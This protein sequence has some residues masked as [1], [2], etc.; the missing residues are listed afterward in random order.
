VP[1]DHAGACSCTPDRQMHVMQHQAHGQALHVFIGS[2]F[3]TVY[4]AL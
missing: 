2:L 1:R 3:L 4:M